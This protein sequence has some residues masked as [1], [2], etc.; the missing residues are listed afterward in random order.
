MCCGK[1]GNLNANPWAD[2]LTDH[3]LGGG[4]VR[5][6]LLQ[7][8]LEGLEKNW[9]DR[10]RHIVASDGGTGGVGE[11]GSHKQRRRAISMAKDLKTIE[12]RRIMIF[13][14]R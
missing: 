10:W 11:I 1:L 2:G 5:I 4:I 7:F 3:H 12:N 6:P 8:S 9:R 13:Q 14:R